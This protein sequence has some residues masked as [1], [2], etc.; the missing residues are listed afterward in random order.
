[1]AL[2]G[3]SSPVPLLRLLRR[4]SW[5]LGQGVPWSWELATREGVRELRRRSR[6]LGQTRR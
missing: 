2:G 3:H 6:G 1:M 5:D 4:R